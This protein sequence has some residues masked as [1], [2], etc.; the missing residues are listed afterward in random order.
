MPYSTQPKVWFWIVALFFIFWNLIGVGFWSTEMIASSEALL[1]GYT[2]AQVA[3]YSS[4]P[5]W[6]S[7]ASGVAVFA[8]LF[9]CIALLLKK[10]QAV[11][12]ALLSLIAVIVC[13]VYEVTVDAW[14]MT[15]GLDHFFMIA[16]PIC[17]VLLWLFARSVQ[18][19]RWLR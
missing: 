9:S 8:G 5:S 10:R 12:L 7:W 16:V 11:L 18:Q 6:Y 17:S 19:K 14:S 13:R 2:A 15:G 4:F 3:F 1:E